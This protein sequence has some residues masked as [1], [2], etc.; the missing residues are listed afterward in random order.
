M[1][2]KDSINRPYSIYLGLRSIPGF[3]PDKFDYDFLGDETDRNNQRVAGH[4]KWA[5]DN[6]PGS[7]PTQRI[8]E[9]IGSESLQTFLDRMSAARNDTPVEIPE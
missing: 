1:Y 3:T 4:A 7:D 2:S 5:S 9:L 8:I 6:P